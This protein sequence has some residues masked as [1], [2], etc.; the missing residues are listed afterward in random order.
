MFFCFVGLWKNLTVNSIKQI[1]QKLSVLKRAT[2]TVGAIWLFAFRIVAYRRLLACICVSATK[3][4]RNAC[5]A[6]SRQYCAAGA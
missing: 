4:Y 6:T 2:R 5:Y 1:Q 3:Q